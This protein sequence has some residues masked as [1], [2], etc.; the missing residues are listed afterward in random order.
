MRGKHVW[1]QL[2]PRGWLLQCFGS[3]RNADGVEFYNEINLYARV[4]SK[5]RFAANKLFSD[6]LSGS[7][8]EP[9]CAVLSNT[10]QH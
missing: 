1:T 9:I 7:E 5:V 8:S 2:S 4:N 6:S 3:C 10:A